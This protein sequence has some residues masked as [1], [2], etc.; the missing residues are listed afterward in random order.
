MKK[1]T[2]R[3]KINIPIYPGRF[4][5]ILTTDPDILEEGNSGLEKTSTD[6]DGILLITV[7]YNLEAQLFSN[8]VISHEC[9]H[10]TIDL[11]NF[12]HL[13]ISTDEDNY[14]EAYTY[15]LSWF[16]NEVYKF[17]KEKKLEIK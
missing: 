16:V 2:Y 12:I 9:L 14:N 7:Y 4:Q 6:D 13:Q 8:G 11:F 1:Y 10:A 15:M 3:K 17:I 5:I